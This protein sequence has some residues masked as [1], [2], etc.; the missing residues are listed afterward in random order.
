MNTTRTNNAMLELQPYWTGA[1]WA[2]DDARVGLVEEPFVLGADQMIT[3]VLQ[4]KNTNFDAVKDGFRM[5]FSATRFPQCDIVIRFEREESGGAWYSVSESPHPA[6][7]PLVSR[8]F[9]GWLCPAMHHYFQ[10]PPEHI[11]MR[12]QA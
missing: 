4:A 6:M 7:N 9:E 12:A 5:Q 11:Y 1:T 10:S 3:A 8:G 2:F